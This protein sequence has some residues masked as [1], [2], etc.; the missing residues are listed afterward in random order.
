V[1]LASPISLPKK[2][3]KKL[4]NKLAQEEGRAMQNS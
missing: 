2:L 4:P 1:A 3:P